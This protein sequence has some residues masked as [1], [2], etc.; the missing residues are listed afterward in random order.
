M[1]PGTLLLTA[2]DVRGHLSMAR[3]IDAVEAAFAALARGHVI[4]PAVLGTHVPNGGFH[5]KTAG[6]TGPRPCYVAK[7]NA[8]FPRNPSAHGLPTIQGV[9]ALF[10]AER[11]ELLALM[12]SIEI[13]GMRT[14]A[15]SAVAAR[16]LAPLNAGTLTIIGCGTQGL[17][18]AR[19]LTQ[20][21]E[22]RRI[23]L[24]DRDRSAAERLAHAIR[25]EFSGAVE[26][27]PDHRAAART[28]DMV[29]TCTTAREPILGADDLP[30][31]GFVAA[32]GADSESKHEI[33]PH[34][35]ARA[36]V[37]VDLLDQCATI[38]DLHHALEAGTM[39]R[40]GVRATLAEVVAGS[41]RGRFAAGET[42]VF[43]ST[44]TA[45]QDVAAAAMIYERAVGN[46]N[47]RQVE[48]GS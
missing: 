14:A 1:P 47:A 5:V 42:I 17:H 7:V 22:I 39:T 48:F 28:S 35:M 8:N 31:G 13:T 29:V 11:G 24:A 19:A 44:G 33:D 30:A 27:A 2:S 25:A 12:D 21:R 32:V 23:R 45:V 38:G 10:D 16:H 43:D 4:P 18:H 40:E 37:V 41:A 26:I 9:V 20:V 34:A 15:A 3:C 36:A 46:P 6:L